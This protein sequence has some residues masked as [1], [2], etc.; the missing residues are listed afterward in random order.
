MKKELLI[1][2]LI[3][4][5]AVFLIK[6]LSNEDDWICV[7][8]DWVKHGVPNAPKPTTLCGTIDSFEECIA[9]GNPAM[10]SFPRQCIANGQTFTEI[11]DLQEQCEINYGTWREEFQEC[12]NIQEDLCDFL[13][14]EF[15]G[16]AY[17]CR[18]E[19]EVEVCITVCVLV[20]S[21]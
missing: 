6:T 5:L 2:I 16:C 19:P 14:G 11:L 17:A 15:D 21:F 10:E 20:C 9:A 13:G 7:D 1:I 12:E 4:I 18:H 3:I 8:D